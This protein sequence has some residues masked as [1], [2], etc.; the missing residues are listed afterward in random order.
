MTSTHR[1]VPGGGGVLTLS[2]P[3]T[4]DNQRSEAA[5]LCKSNTVLKKRGRK[6]KEISKETKY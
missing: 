3:W 1:G 5:I 4:A 6:E 2:L